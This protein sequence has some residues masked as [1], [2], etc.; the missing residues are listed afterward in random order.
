[1]VDQLLAD[2][3]GRGAMIAGIFS[4]N[5]TVLIVSMVV[6]WV[7]FWGAFS[8]VVFGSWHR[9]AYWWLTVGILGPLGPIVALIAASAVSRQRRDRVV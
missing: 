3:A 2:A 4:T 6:T 8:A 1:M 9:P 7:V 5:G